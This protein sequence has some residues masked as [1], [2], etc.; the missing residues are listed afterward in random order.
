MKEISGW[1]YALMFWGYIAVKFV[2]VS[3]A[4]WSWWWVLVPLV[5]WLSL[6]VKRFGL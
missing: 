4:A 2:G 3:F 1:L 6:A 5:P